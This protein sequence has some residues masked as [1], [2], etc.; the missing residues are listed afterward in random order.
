MHNRGVKEIEVCVTT[1]PANRRRHIAI[2]MPTSTVADTPMA[3]DTTP[4]VPIDGPETP[5]VSL[6][7]TNEAA[8]ATMT[9]R[10]DGLLRDAKDI[11]IMVRAM[12]KDLRKQNRTE[13]ARFARLESQITKT[14]TRRGTKRAPGGAQSG[15]TV[16]VTLDP[17]LS[18]LIGVEKDTVMYR[19]EV[20]K[21]LTSYIKANELQTPENRRNF[22]LDAPLAAAFDMEEGQLTNWFEMQK[23]MN[24]LLTKCATTSSADTTDTTDTIDTR[25]LATP[26]ME[27]EAPPGSPVKRKVVRRIKPTPTDP[28]V[29]GNI[30]VLVG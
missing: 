2:N 20:T 7:Q 16:S 17:R 14:K 5:M 29:N 8:L 15:L 3:P 30:S 4:E 19:S 28:V 22:T 21:A 12:M 23:L 18:T 1:T 25:P 10:I 6:A 9:D 11:G 13:S 27:T 24:K 26:P